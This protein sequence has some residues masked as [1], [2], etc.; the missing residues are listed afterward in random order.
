MEDLR[1]QLNVPIGDSG[2]DVAIR[3]GRYADIAQAH[4]EAKYGEKVATW[5]EEA[6]EED[7]LFGPL[8]RAVSRKLDEETKNQYEA[9]EPLE[10]TDY[11]G[12]T[13]T[14]YSHIKPEVRFPQ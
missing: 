11:Y 10:G 12:G 7:R 5:A 8:D 2:V 3:A 13:K 1:T 4:V 14:R 9:E 6:A